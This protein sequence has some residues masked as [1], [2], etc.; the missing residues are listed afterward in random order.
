[1]IKFICLHTIIRLEV[2]L[3][4][5]NKLQIDLLEAQIGSKK[6][7]PVRVRVDLGVMVRK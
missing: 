7:R 3:S 4:N 2:F 5:T 1:M 6:V